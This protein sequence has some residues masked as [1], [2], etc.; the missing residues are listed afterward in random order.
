MS[1]S[2]ASPASP[3]ARSRR[4]PTRNAIISSSAKGW[5]PLQISKRDSTASL[6]PPPPVMS[7]GPR[8][9]S[10]SF[11][12]VA[13]NSL[14]SN[15]IFKSPQPNNDGGDKII[16][17]RRNTRN[18]GE[19]APSARGVGST[20]RGVIGLGLSP[21]RRS[22][23]RSPNG[24]AAVNGQR[25]VSAEKAKVTF[26]GVER[27]VSK[28]NESPD[29]RHSMRVPRSSMG[30][31]GLQTGSYVSQSPFKR[32]SSTTLSSSSLSQANSSETPSPKLKL[33]VEKDDVFSSPSPRRVSGGK[34][35]RVSPGAA[36]TLGSAYRQSPTPSPRARASVSPASAGPSPLRRELSADIAAAF[37]ASPTP[38]PH[39]SSM[40]PSRRLRGPRDA[41]QGYDSPSKKSVTFQAI[42]DVK[43]YE[44]VSAEPSMDGSFDVDAGMGDEAD[45]E[46]ENRENSLDNMLSEQIEPSEEGHDGITESSTADF[47]DTLVEEGL[48][49]PPEMDTPAFSDQDGYELPLESSYL[50]LNSQTDDS[51]RPYLATPSLGG[52]VN[53]SPLF[54]SHETFP[55]VD[56]AG[57]PYGRTHHAERASE[58][59]QHR[60]DVGRFE[61]PSLPRDGGHGMLLNA[62]ASKP[63]LS[64]P[65]TSPSFYH[66]YNDPFASVTPSH[67]TPK[68]KAAPAPA[69]EPHAHQTGPFPDPFLTIQTATAT[70]NPEHEEREE[71]GVP[72][73]RTSHKERVLAARMMA[74]RG[75]G[76]GLPGRP[77][78]G[79]PSPQP[80]TQAEFEQAEEVPERKLPKAPA[81]APA[82]IDLPSPVSMSKNE[83]LEE[84]V[85]NKNLLG[86]MT[87]P[88]IDKTS[89]FF[90][91]TS[92]FDQAPAP[93]SESGSE[94]ASE[95]VSSRPTS[96]ESGL[97]MTEDP[98]LTPPRRMGEST[99]AESPHRLPDF[100]FGLGSID[101][102]TVGST[103]K[104][105]EPKIIREEEAKPVAAVAKPEE[106]E[107]VQEKKKAPLGIP[108]TMS[109]TS[110]NRHS[111][112]ASPA[113]PTS[114]AST[115]PRQPKTTHDSTTNRIRQRISRE[116]IRETIQQ[117]LADGSLSR[118]PVSMGSGAELDALA[119]GMEKTSISDFGVEGNKD[120]DLP[121]PPPE[122][123]ALPSTPNKVRP[124]S[125]ILSRMRTPSTPQSASKQTTTS[126]PGTPTTVERP[127]M[128][129]RSQTQ[130][131]Q[132]VF[133]QSE[134][135]GAEA[136]SALDKIVSLVRREHGRK[137]S[138]VGKPGGAGMQREVSG[139]IGDVMPPAPR[140]PS[141]EAKPAGILK[142]PNGL[143]DTAVQD[144]PRRVSNNVRPP[145][146]L[147]SSSTSSSSSDKKEKED[148]RDDRPTA[149]EQALITKRRGELGR[150]RQVSGVS[151]VSQ[152]SKKSRR[153]MSMG[154]VGEQVAQAR[155]FRQKASSPPAAASTSN[156][157]VSALKNGPAVKAG[158]GIRGGRL[159]L[160]IDDDERSILDSFREEVG[161]IGSDR[162]YKIRERPVVRASYN[163]KVA[164]S[165]AGDIDSGKAWKALRRPSDLHE[166]SAKIKEIRARE[167]SQNPASATV[168]VKVLGIEGLQFPIPNGEGK[169]TMFCVTLDNSIDY[170]RT[171]FTEL[172]EGARVNQEF[173]L[174]EHPNFEFSLSVDIRRDPHILK[175]IHDKNNPA[176]AIPRPIASASA[177]KKDSHFRNLFASP[178]KPKGPTAMVGKA[179]KE[180]ASTPVKATLAP[181]QPAAPKKDTI[182]NYLPEGNGNVSTIAKTHI[183]FKTIAKNCEARVLEIRYPMFS[184][185]KGD[186]TASLS[187]APSGSSDGSSRKALAK[188]TL[189]VF[190]LPPIPGLM[191]DE[192]PQCI[193]DC[194]RGLRYHAW[195]EHEYFEG[196]L[197]Q[198]GGDCSHPKRRLFKILG[199]NLI[200]INE[201]TKK[202]VA[203]IDLRQAVSITDLNTATCGSPNTVATRRGD[204]D[205]DGGFGQRPRSFE[206]LFQDGEAIVFMADTDKA[207]EGWMETLQ[208]LIGKIPANPLW[209][210]LLTLRMREKAAKRSA[211]SGS[212]AAKEARKSEGKAKR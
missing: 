21:V 56:E 90:Q 200:A 30:L 150:E 187:S 49:S 192:L 125:E 80:A 140:T 5:S 193:D 173:S 212:L 165:R 102:G 177:P 12:V 116:M 110:L 182:S 195:H 33:P 95:P 168:F 22:E 208:G 144:A 18:L 104:V 194:L 91:A 211:S 83:I 45:W 68:A 84:P 163:D 127:Q 8:R 111:M 29:V 149:K 112:P 146:S 42:P 158:R 196:T 205:E 38:T 103:K 31:K 209:A 188:V 78:A 92:A 19:M 98:P 71:D 58:A 27:K 121:A 119:K 93:A 59:H 47:M 161:N 162:G 43:E 126:N 147:F 186:P 16:H 183:Q 148:A 6:S 133:K 198:D 203:K 155:E 87:L 207:K 76:L 128:R 179:G 152:G 77:T 73:G 40:T 14:V 180:R 181:P 34:Q 143:L 106:K 114:H 13:N 23:S 197:T 189:Q 124:K 178:R 54:A 46:D 137:S 184:M 86:A 171:P 117:R 67:T 120:K 57:I 191:P 81:P 50:D 41:L 156:T 4:D 169:K 82:P 48:F 72:L 190:R 131:A 154:D 108:Q 52:S 129:Q 97:Q 170:I 123:P 172:G 75:L 51:D 206:M 101:F 65:P 32:P 160:G 39:K 153:S 210:E 20:P 70:F 61:Q 28:E 89:P 7:D 99:E 100:D 135:S 199:G 142:N 3:P 26:P 44:V 136:K 69:P 201:V 79:P 96:P 115:S 134:E 9:T 157:P 11:K 175:L 2:P 24:G 63:S 66:D 159:T 60:L 166:H 10:S 53:A 64:I 105:V 62:D 113:S 151:M 141:K 139:T 185:F 94:S 25:K 35:R 176:P 74:T 15:S 37:D 132:E 138:E 174:V 85:E 36:G 167:L 164:H 107:K 118:R 17:E 145:S 130:S 122:S 55:E 109:T 88:S 202:Q 1:A 204:Y